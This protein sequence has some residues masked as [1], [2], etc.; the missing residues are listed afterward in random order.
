MLGNKAR[1]TRPELALRRELHSRGLRFRVALKPLPD[2]RRT[3]D[4][5]FTRYRLAV[6]IDGCY[7]HGCPDH[8]RPASI[9]AEFWSSKIAANRARDLETTARLE[10]AGWIVLRFWEHE[11][12]TAA[13]DRVEVELRRLQAAHRER[14]PRPTES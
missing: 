11:S 1:D 14:S 13:A 8:Y 9:N 12:V 6:F 5:A 10:D 4:V 2:L 3:V 7:W